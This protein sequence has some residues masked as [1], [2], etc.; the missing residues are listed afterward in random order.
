MPKEIRRQDI[1]PEDLERGRIL[2]QQGHI[3]RLVEKKINGKRTNE[4]VMMNTGIVRSYS[5]ESAL[6]MI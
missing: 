4:M 3:Y 2:E 6:K 1:K 5:I